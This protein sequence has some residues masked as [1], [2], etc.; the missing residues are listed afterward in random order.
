VLH[1]FSD[2]SLFRNLYAW[3]PLDCAASQ[4]WTKSAKVLI[5]FDAPIDPIDKARV[6]IDME[7]QLGG[8]MRSLG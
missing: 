3:T 6:S 5:E 2:L 8:S 1:S 7:E 4:G